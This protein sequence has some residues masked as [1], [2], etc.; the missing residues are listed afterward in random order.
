MAN[1]SKEGAVAAVVTAA[2]VGVILATVIPHSGKDDIPVVKITTEPTSGG[3]QTAVQPSTYMSC[4]DAQQMPCVEE[5]DNGWVLMESDP[6]KAAK[7]TRVL[8]V[9]HFGR[10]GKMYYEVVR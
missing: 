5:T 2:V 4:A 10:Q 1:V 6:G 7:Q 9:R 3:M 8:I